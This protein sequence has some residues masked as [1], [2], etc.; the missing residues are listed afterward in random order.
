M[1][2]GSLNYGFPEQP[3]IGLME[4]GADVHSQIPP[5]LARFSLHALA[6]TA[7]LYSAG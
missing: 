3:H 7:L 1:K 6:Y 2:F 4:F 5:L